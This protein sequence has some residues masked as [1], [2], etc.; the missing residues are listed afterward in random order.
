M[1]KILFIIPNFQQNISLNTK[2]FYVYLFNPELAYTLLMIW[3]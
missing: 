3:L 2:Q 1:K